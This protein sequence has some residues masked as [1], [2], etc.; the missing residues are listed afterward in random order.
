MKL[1]RMKKI[2]AC[3]LLILIA[4]CTNTAKKEDGADKNETSIWKHTLTDYHVS[5]GKEEVKLD[6]RLNDYEELE[7]IHD[8]IDKGDG[9]YEYPEY[10]VTIGKDK[11]YLKTMDDEIIGYV[12]K[13][14]DAKDMKIDNTIDFSYSIE[15]VIAYLGTPM[16]KQTKDELLYYVYYD[17]HNTLL[18]F[19]FKDNK[20]ERVYAGTTRQDVGRPVKRSVYTN[21]PVSSKE[22][23]I[24]TIM[25]EDTDLTKLKTVQEYVQDGWK[26]ISEND[27][28]YKKGESFLS[29]NS[30]QSNLVKAGRKTALKINGK[31]IIGQ[32]AKEILKDLGSPDCYVMPAADRNGEFRYREGS[33]EFDIIVDAFGKVTSVNLPLNHDK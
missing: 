2:V 17:L 7:M 10:R 4:G 8:K 30:D 14:N 25:V 1:A 29:L 15:K 11:L 13:K 5:I 23:N 31:A 28:V 27:G 22:K 24:Q 26:A 33:I 18:A 3:S 6:S 16:I 12:F 20:M 9:V 21:I 32:S 19:G